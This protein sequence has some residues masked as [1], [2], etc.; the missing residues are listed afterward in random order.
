M[1][2]ATPGDHTSFSIDDPA[3]R[4][5]LDAIGGTDAWNPG[6]PLYDPIRHVLVHYDSVQAV[7]VAHRWDAG[8]RA[9]EE[10][11]RKPLRN[12]VQILCWAETGELVVEDASEPAIDM[13]A[14][15]ASADVVVLD[16]DTGAELGRAPIGAPATFGMFCCPGF[17]RDLYVASLPGGVARIH[18]IPG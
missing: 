7:V 2:G 10:L 11:W 8:R 14:G 17:D 3:D 13:A 12:F 5:V 18:V 6:P 15:S 9:L 1:S 4:D 16:I